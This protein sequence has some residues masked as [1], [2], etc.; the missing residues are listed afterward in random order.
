MPGRGAARH[1]QSPQESDCISFHPPSSRIESDSPED[2]TEAELRGISETATVLGISFVLPSHL[3]NPSNSGHETVAMNETPLAPT[4]P[5]PVPAPPAPTQSLI[6]RFL[7]SF[8]QERN[9]KW[10]LAVGMSILF[11]SSL[12]LVTS[13]W[14]EYTPLWQNFIVLAYSVAIHFA[15]QWTYH[16]MGLRKTGHV[17]QGLT[18]LLIPVLFLVI[19]W[20][21]ADSLADRPPGFDGELAALPTL[22]LWFVQFSATA[23]FAALAA[24]RVFAFFLRST[25]PTF[26]TCYLILSAAG[27]VLPMTPE[28]WTPFVA[29]G[30]WATFAIGSV[31]IARH[32]FWLTEEYRQ[33]RI[34]GFLPIALL[35]AQFLFLYTAHPAL[36]VSFEWTG[37]GCALVAIPILATA[38]SLA[39]VFQ[40]RTG[41]LVRPLP[42]SVVLPIIAGAILCVAGLSLAGMSVLPPLRPYALVATAAVV[43]G[44]MLTLARRTSK[45]AFVWAM[46]V[47]LAVV[48]NFSPLFFMEIVKTVL[49]QSAEMVRENRLPFAFYGLTYMPFLGMLIAG[50]WLSARASNDHF[51][52]PMKRFAL[53]LTTVLLG[54]SLTHEKALFPVGIAIVAVSAV[55]VQRLRS[56]PAIALGIASWLT[57]AY[58]LPGFAEKVLGYGGFANG[59]IACLTIGAAGLFVVGILRDRRLVDML[60]RSV[61]AVVPQPLEMASLGIALGLVG[62]WFVPGIIGFSL[63]IS[64]SIGGLLLMHALRQPRPFVSA[65]AIVFLQ[66]VTLRWFAMPALSKGEFLSMATWLFLGQW[67]AG[68]VLELVLRGPAAATLTRVNRLICRVW[69]VAFAVTI[70]LPYSLVDILGPEFCE[71]FTIVDLPKMSFAS[72]LAMLLWTIDY[73]RRM[74]SLLSTTLAH[75]SVLAAVG[76]AA[77]LTWGF[78]VWIWLPALFAA[79]GILMQ[80][81]A[82][83]LERRPGYDEVVQTL[84]SLNV[85]MFTL[86]AVGTLAM[87]DW[88]MRIAGMFAIAGLARIVALSPTTILRRPLLMLLNLQAFAVVATVISPTSNVMAF[89]EHFE[90]FAQAFAAAAAVSLLAWELLP[91]DRDEAVQIATQ[92]FAF[93]LRGLWLFAIAVTLQWPGL[94]VEQVVMSIIAFVLLGGSELAAAC[95]DKNEGRVWI[96]EAIVV[97]AVLYFFHFG[98]ITLQHGL[99]MFVVL[100]VGV[101]LKVV[102]E[103]TAKSPTTAILSRPMRLTSFAMPLVAVGVGVTRHIAGSDVAWLGANSLA[104]LLAAAFYFWR[105][106][107]TLR[108]DLH[109]LA[110]VILNIALVLLWRELTWSDPQLFMTPIGISI[111]ALVELLRREIPERFHNPLRYLGALVILVSPTFHIVGGG[112]WIPLFTLM[113]ASVAIALLAIGLRI[114]A[115]LYTGTAFLIA[116]LAA[117]LIRGGIENSNLLWIAGFLLGAAII[118]LGAY[119]EKHRET[120]L[121]RMHLLASTLKTW[122]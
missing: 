73:A 76:S 109:V 100:G 38:D 77:A 34:L 115:L 27:A 40:Q 96:A 54:M 32:V 121:V 16:R 90:I 30:L 118:A 43:S 23:L 67:L 17:L 80:L 29:A 49:S 25:Q 81:V 13:H 11:G 101:G 70:F 37:F 33:P 42:W 2:V 14:Q 22:T 79:T 57:A 61:A 105:G 75:L 46:L 35:G 103:F 9:I 45:E 47:C 97:A 110:A 51:A 68:G 55:Q 91:E 94:T 98:I 99:G 93:I 111:L 52:R 107:E 21:P 7:D 44:L 106:L 122:N 1:W 50:S 85:A 74:R 6:V 59:H 10:V 53:L 4:S 95:R 108:K 66:F 8:L 3:M 92:G 116:D 87:F 69:L 65:I 84:K 112:S 5:A 62:C 26:L 89:A 60:P 24:R 113:V 88:P 18:V 12:L 117:M 83:R 28:A 114:R 41:N 120:L 119:C 20:M 39:R 63:P 72:R 48:Y 82:E 102:G 71:S 15:G 86:T 31:K 56:W 78:G 36:H 19:R 58:G 104:L 64:L